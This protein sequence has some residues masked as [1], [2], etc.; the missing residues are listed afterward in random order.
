[1]ER[2]VNTDIQSLKIIYSRNK[3]F[4]VPGIVIFVS[5]ILIILIIVPQI[6]TL[7]EA[8]EEGKFAS[9]R[10]EKL[11][12]DLN[13]LQTLDGETLESQRKTSTMALPVNKDFGGILNALFTASQKTGV[14]IGRF[15]F[16]IGDISKEEQKDV[17][18]SVISLKVSL[19]NDIQRVNSFIS[20]IQKTVPLSA[21][22]LITT[23][24][25]ISTIDL[26]FYYKV[27]PPTGVTKDIVISPLSQ[28]KKSLLDRINSFNNVQSI[29]LPLQT[30]TSSPK[31]TNPFAP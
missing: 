11:K 5:L 1:M 28:E 18:F 9:Q 24:N 2:R 7:F 17:N 14:R 20:E 16:Q 6:K 12:K 13:T 21:I 29:N 10:L 31:S 26:L 30:S 15:S 19:E 8:Q 25:R 4:I 22:D 27:L 3:Y 23:D